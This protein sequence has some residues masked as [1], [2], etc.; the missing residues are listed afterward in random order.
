[1]A[2]V[3]TLSI[4]SK[5]FFVN[6]LKHPNNAHHHHHHQEPSIHLCV[7]EKEKVT[8]LMVNKKILTSYLNSR[9]YWKLFEKLLTWLDHIGAETSIW[10]KI[11]KRNKL[12]YFPIKSKIIDSMVLQ[13]HDNLQFQDI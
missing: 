6:Y 5:S 2:T 13:F 8:I 12:F 11:V 4:V 7:R 1:M 3:K 10:S 9:F